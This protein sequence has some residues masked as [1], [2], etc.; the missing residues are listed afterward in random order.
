[1]TVEKKQ[2]V[3]FSLDPFLAR[4]YVA[5]AD[6]LKTALNDPPTRR[7]PWGKHMSQSVNKT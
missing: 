5:C 7:R 2:G 1:M 4:V 3:H 6:G